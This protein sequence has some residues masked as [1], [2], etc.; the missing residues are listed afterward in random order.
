MASTLKT[1]V[2][3]V[4]LVL[5]LL[6]ML[7]AKDGNT[8]R[9]FRVFF[10]FNTLFLASLAWLFFTQSSLIENPKFIGG[11]YLWANMSMLVPMVLVWGFANQEYT[12]GTAAIQYPVIGILFVSIGLF[13]SSRFIIWAYAHPDTYGVTLTATSI[14]NFLIL[15]VYLGLTNVELGFREK[16][17]DLK[18]GYTI[19]LAVVVFSIAYVKR[20]PEILFKAQVRS[21]IPDSSSYATLM[22]M[23]GAWEL[24]AV[25]CSFVPALL[26]GL[27]LYFV[28]GP[29]WFSWV[30]GLVTILV[31]LIGF[32][33]FGLLLDPQISQ[34]DL[35]LIGQENAFIFALLGMLVLLKELAFFGISH[36]DRL[37]TKIAID[38]IVFSSVPVLANATLVIGATICDGLLQ[39]GDFYTALFSVAL[40]LCIVAFYRIHK[41]LKNGLGDS[42]ERKIEE[43][44]LAVV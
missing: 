21:L 28:N 6:L 22:G 17:K 5:G 1:C 32:S 36:K 7:L 11:F 35:L 42:G 31:F 29:R 18:W 43:H 30:C 34:A 9:V 4:A 16:G 3:P 10:S 19:A 12:F 26:I 2:V 27:I 24:G 44:T 41:D 39:S 20:F 37:S 15:L 25:L 8:K 33:I 23:C 13:I 38:L 40:V 14:L